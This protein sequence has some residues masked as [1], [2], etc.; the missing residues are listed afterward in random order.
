[1]SMID[2]Q[3]GN[4]LNMQNDLLIL[5]GRIALSSLPASGKKPFL[6]LLWALGLHR[7][8]ST[9]HHPLHHSLPL[10][11]GAA[12]VPHGD[13]GAEDTLHRSC[14]GS[15]TAEL[16]PPPLQRAAASWESRGA[17]WSL[18]PHRNCCSWIWGPLLRLLQRAAER[19][20]SAAEIGAV[21]DEQEDVT[22]LP[23]VFGTTE[24]SLS[25]VRSKEKL[26][27]LQSFRQTQ[28]ST[29]W[30]I[31]L[32]VTGKHNSENVFCAAK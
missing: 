25:L 21:I 22:C 31:C 9:L 6:R 3:H 32:P 28:N 16:P 23:G 29:L 12:A 19:G 18:W 15:F 7:L 11:C 20:R 13:A 4:H 1:M 27:V 30:S 17:G 24:K 26:E 14:G 10:G 5:H 2:V 8:L